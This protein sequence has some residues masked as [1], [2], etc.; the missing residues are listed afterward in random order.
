LLPQL[1]NTYRVRRT[2][3]TGLLIEVTGPDDAHRLAAA[4]TAC[5]LKGVIDVVPAMQTVLVAIDPDQTTLD[6]IEP[7]I[8]SL[9][10]AP[11]TD[12]EPARVTV[13][14]IYDG[15]DLE[16]VAEHCGLT[17]DDVIA[18]H[19]NSLWRAAFCGF[20]PGY[21]YLIGGDPRLEVPRRGES[22]VRVPEGSVG[23][24]GPFS[25]VYPRESPGGWQ[26]IGRTNVRLWDEHVDPPAIITPG[27]VVS[28]ENVNG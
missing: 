8:R 11:D 21:A 10:S 1:D 17:A 19:T 28:F 7:D 16:F 24:A 6:K 14:V 20:V 5:N 9:E 2:G 25:A 26:L 3:D 27:T 23:L 18:A 22:R 13:P 15:A 4:V 12:S